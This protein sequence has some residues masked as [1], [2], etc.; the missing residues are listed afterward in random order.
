MHQRKNFRGWL[1]CLLTLLLLLPSCDPGRRPG[2]AVVGKAAPDLILEDLEGRTFRL[3]DLRGQV[4]FLHFWATW[5]PPCREEMPS[6]EALHREMR[7]AGEP[8]QILAV[9]SNDD[10]GQAARFAEKLGLTFPILKDPETKV[11]RIYGVTGVP[12]TFIIDSNGILRERFIG[13]RPWES[14]EA[15]QILRSYMHLP[16]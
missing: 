13:A 10:P 5:C 14:P 7:L 8:F 2:Q 11:A 15:K 9:L 16:E 12:E 3:A 1:L 4:V 6:M